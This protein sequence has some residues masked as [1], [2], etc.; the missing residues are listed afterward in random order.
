MPQKRHHQ[1]MKIHY[2]NVIL[3]DDRDIILNDD[4]NVILNDYS[5]VI[6]NVSEESC[7]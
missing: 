2:S 6:L 1:R 7:C 3:N 4:R 5:N